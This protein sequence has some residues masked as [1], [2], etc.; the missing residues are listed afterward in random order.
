MARMTREDALTA[1]GTMTDDDFRTVSREE[2]GINDG[3]IERLVEAG[4]RLVGR[5]SLTAPGTVS[6]QITVRL[7]ES[8]NQQLT[9]LAAQTGRR[10]SQV[11]RDAVDAYLTMV[12]Q[13]AGDG[14][15]NC[16]GVSQP[17]FTEITE[18]LA[19]AFRYEPATV[20]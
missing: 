8:V 16:D 12:A 7:S 18:D 10:R 20:S 6:P 4:H 11:V 2:S 3:L 15:S 14:G 13:R 1:L 19:C 5:P 9:A 17:P